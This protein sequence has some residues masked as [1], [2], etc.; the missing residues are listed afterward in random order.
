M[1][2]PCWFRTCCTSGWL[3]TSGPNSSSASSG[4]MNGSPVIAYCIP[5]GCDGV[6]WLFIRL[7]TWCAWPSMTSVSSGV[8][9]T[10]GPS[11]KVGVA[12]AAAAVRLAAP[13]CVVLFPFCG[14]APVLKPPSKG[15]IS[16]SLKT[17]CPPKPLWPNMSSS[18][19]PALAGGWTGAFEEVGPVGPFAA[20]FPAM[21]LLPAAPAAAFG[22]ESDARR[23]IPR[24]G[25]ANFLLAPFSM[26]R[27]GNAGSEPMM[28]TW[29]FSFSICP[30]GRFIEVYIGVT[31]AVLA[32]GT[33]AANWARDIVDCAWMLCAGTR[34]GIWL[35]F[36][37]DCS[38]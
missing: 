33:P 18:P 23:R 22:L 35:K 16:C 7:S 38:L 12:P 11:P 4:T 5:V 32:G 28:M 36:I 14:A 27:V 24:F 30:E 17:G 10:S 9:M 20:P 25:V 26:D 34:G 37:C 29:L 15:L 2:A 13:P 8:S 31:G 3:R 21:P 1:R 6:V 19:Q